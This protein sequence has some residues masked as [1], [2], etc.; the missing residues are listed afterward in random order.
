MRSYFFIIFTVMLIVLGSSCRKDFQYTPSSGNLEFSKDTVFLDTVFSTIGS[1]TRTL[2]VYNRTREDIEIPSIRLSQGQSS[3][4]RLNVDGAA[5]K[6]FN[7]IPI[8]AKDSIFIFI[9]TTF[10]VSETNEN[11]FL[12]TDAIQFDASENQQE[13]QLVT[14]VK[15]AIFLYPRQLSNGLK[16]TIPIGLDEAGNEVRTEGFELEDNQLNFTD[17]KPYVIYGYAAIP[18][19]KE[20]TI[21][22]GTRVHFHKDS[23]MF[24]NSN[25]SIQIN[26]A[27]SED[28]E[29]LENEV[30]FSGDRLEAELSDVPGQWGTIWISAGSVNNSINHLTLKN[31]I[32]GILV[33]GNELL[34]S[35]TLKI[36]NTQIYNSA[37]INLWGRRAF[38]EGENVVLGSSGNSSLYLNLGGKYE[39][40]HCTVA[41]YWSNG[42]RGGATLEIDNFTESLAYDLE[43]A[44]FVNCIIDGSNS[45][46]MVLRNNNA[47]AFQYSF[48]NCLL[49]FRDINKQFEDD[50][51]YNFEDL[52]FYQEV[53]LNE[54]ANFKDP[55]KNNFTVESPSAAA[56]RG[57]TEAALKV[58]FDILG[59]P[60][61][62]SPTI[63]ANQI[64]Q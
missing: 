52:S 46:E 20:L 63:G 57:N 25:A 50:P 48:T 11:E 13:V 53:F 55:S 59:I 38:I 5:G 61:T 62:I 28:K 40:V 6:E 22:A 16:E 9:E 26:G 43:Q 31:A 34:Q 42:F 15:D 17:Q 36:K 10:D 12:Y 32:V 49:K 4:Y 24:I 30:V 41:N 39:F 8:L 58:P 2:K 14:L 44:D 21:E 7:N 45:I 51:L 35:P 19:G 33:E 29:L 27:L 64:S 18:E 47:A 23:G 3:S 54:D 37:S 1:S 56:E 60:R